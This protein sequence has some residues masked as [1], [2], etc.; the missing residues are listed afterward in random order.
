MISA[1]RK[2]NG[3]LTVITDHAVTIENVDCLLLAIGRTSN[4]ADLALQN[5]GQIFDKFDNNCY[6]L[7]R[8]EICVANFIPLHF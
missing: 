6:Q 3:N 2:S 7:R 1:A 4:T 8:G 5:A